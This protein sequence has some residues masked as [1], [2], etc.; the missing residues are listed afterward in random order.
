MVIVVW[1]VSH[2]VFLPGIAIKH[3]VNAPSSCPAERVI[4]ALSNFGTFKFANANGF[5]VSM[6]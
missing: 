3:S 5:Y 4:I 6:D 2:P 1:P